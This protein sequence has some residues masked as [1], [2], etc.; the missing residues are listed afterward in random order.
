MATFN[1]EKFVTTLKQHAAQ[2][3]GVTVA[4]LDPSLISLLINLASGLFTGCM[5]PSTPTPASPASVAAQLK[6]PSLI[7]TNV[8]K[9]RARRQAIEAGQP[10]SHGDIA[11]AALL[12]AC[13]AT[14]VEDLTLAITDAN[15][16][17]AAV[18]QL[19]ML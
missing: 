15:T 16:D 10:R 5:N 9:Q 17:A 2:V 19:D 3:S 12:S 4:G 14:S 6:S 13:A 7:Q 11:A 1:D 18:P 8:L